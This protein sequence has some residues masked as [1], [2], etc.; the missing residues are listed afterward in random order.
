MTTGPAAVSGVPPDHGRAGG[1]RIEREHSGDSA[2]AAAGRPGQPT[3]AVR[4][5][6][7]G[8]SNS[9]SRRSGE[10]GAVGGEGAAGRAMV[11]LSAR[12]AA[13]QARWRCAAAALGTR[14]EENWLRKK[15]ARTT[16]KNIRGGQQRP[17][18]D[19]PANSDM[20]TIRLFY[21]SPWIAARPRA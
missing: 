5:D 1:K 17:I 4:R 20:K 3:T 10:G 16:A 21:T 9:G 15:P 18:I 19:V 7:R 2:T 12:W 13:Q 8:T 6:E 14:R 11:A